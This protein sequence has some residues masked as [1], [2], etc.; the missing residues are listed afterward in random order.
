MEAT[1]VDSEVKEEQREDPNLRLGI[2]S[3]Q[4]RVKEENVLTVEEAMN[5]ASVPQM[6]RNASTVGR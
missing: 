6:A 1:E 5:K 3:V 2:G 4:D